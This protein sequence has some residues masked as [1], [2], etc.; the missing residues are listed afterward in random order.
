MALVFAG[1]AGNFVPRQNYPEWLQTLSLV[2]PN[3][4]ALE[5]F[6]SLGSGGGLA[7]VLLPVIALTIMGVVLFVVSTVLF[8]RQYR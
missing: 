4:W 5:G 8:R 3:A 6:Q 2:T 7:D 1:L